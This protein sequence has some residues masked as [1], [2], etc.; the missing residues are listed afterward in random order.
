MRGPNVGLLCVATPFLTRACMLRGLLRCAPG[1]TIAI[2]SPS[3]HPQALNLPLLY[4][5]CAQ[6]LY[7]Q[8]RRLWGRGAREGRQAPAPAREAGR[9]TT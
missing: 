7:L 1:L 2:S 6:H 8:C 3:V 4:L 9:L 5:L